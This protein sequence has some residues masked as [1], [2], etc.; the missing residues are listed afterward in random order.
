MLRL[1]LCHYS[2]LYIIV[3]GRISVT[4]TKNAKRR[5][6]KLTFKKNAPFWSCISKIDKTCTDNAE[7]FDV[8]LTLSCYSDV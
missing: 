4:S 8:I 1:D 5:N 2:D 6:K 7:G 3:K